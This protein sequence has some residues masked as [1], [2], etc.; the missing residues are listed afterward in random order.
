MPCSH[1][2]VGAVHA[3][4]VHAC[5]DDERFELGAWAAWRPGPAQAGQ[6]VVEA[7]PAVGGGV[8]PGGRDEVGQE[9]LGEYDVVGSPLLVG[10]S[11]LW[12]GYSRHRRRRM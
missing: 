10:E 11:L 6:H 3:R 8:L 1:V 9:Q 4:D 5:R 12:L 2:G 7:H